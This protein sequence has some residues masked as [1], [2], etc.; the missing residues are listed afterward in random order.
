MKIRLAVLATAITC[1][2][3][4]FPS[5]APSIIPGKSSNWIFAPLYLMQP[6]NC[7]NKPYQFF[8]LVTQRL[9]ASIENWDNIHRIKDER[10]IS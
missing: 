9:M 4:P 5:F 3:L 10:N 8:T 6:K 2:P 1:R 7:I